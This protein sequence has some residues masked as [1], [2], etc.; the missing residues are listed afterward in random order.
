MKK[1]LLTLA[2]MF[3]TVPAVAGEDSN[4]TEY[5]KAEMICDIAADQWMDSEPGLS[6]DDIH[7]MF[8]DCVTMVTGEK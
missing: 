4:F 1:A 6:A 3:V 8:L 7:G 2:L 5:E